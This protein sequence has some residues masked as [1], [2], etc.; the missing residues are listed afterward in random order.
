MRADH[1]TILAFPRGH[2]QKRDIANRPSVERTRLHDMRKASA[3]R[4]S[5]GR[6]A[7]HMGRSMAAL[8][9]MPDQPRLQ[10]ED[11]ADAPDTRWELPRILSFNTP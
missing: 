9:L 10:I 5:L 11:L 8:L 3:G 4:Q 7:R 1:E 6:Q 2:Q